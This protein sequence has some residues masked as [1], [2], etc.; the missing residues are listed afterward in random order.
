LT[1]TPPGGNPVDYTHNLTFTGGS[2]P[3]QI[4]Q[5]FGRQGDTAVLV[6]LDEYRMTPNFTIPVMSQIK[7]VDNYLNQTLFAGV[8][9]DPVLSPVSA[10]LNEWRLGCTDYTY[11]ADHSTPVYGPYYNGFTADAV[12]IALTEQADCGITAAPTSQGGFVAPAVMLPSVAINYQALSSAWRLLA[13]LSSQVTPYG[14]YVD[15]QLRLHFYDSTT[16]LDSGVTFTTEP[17]QGGSVS[18]GHIALDNQFGYEWDG[19]S[20]HNRVLV[21]GAAQTIYSRPQGPPTDTWL[22][23]G[24]GSAWPLRFTFAGVQ[25]LTINGVSTQADQLHPGQPHDT[26]ANWFIEQNANGAWFLTSANPPAAGTVIKFWYNYQIPVI[27]VANDYASQAAYPG[28]N[29]GIF[30]D[31]ISDQGLT[32]TSMALARAQRERA[33]FAF[34]AEK[35]TFNTTEDFVGWIRSGQTFGYNTAMAPDSRNNYSW[36]L[37]GRFLCTQ[38]RIQFVSGGYRQMTITGVRI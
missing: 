20:I 23:D 24:I 18:E 15:E 38:N 34:A 7:L 37:N 16:A 22:A 33:E 17:T 4:Q 6:L 27:G 35:V 3:P 25:R 12:V 10:T 5:N 8:V 13:R 28:P 14:W 31:Y 2:T 11:Y 19:T 21:Q 36:G 32:T 26:Q 1:I 29:H 30:G 9:N